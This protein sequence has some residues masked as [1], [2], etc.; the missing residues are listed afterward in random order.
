MP[1]PVARCLPARGWPLKIANY[2][3]ALVKYS[4]Y[5]GSTLAFALN[6]LGHLRRRLPAAR[7]ECE[8]VGP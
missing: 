3:I 6:W 1:T 5:I 2:I 4:A 8:S 7:G